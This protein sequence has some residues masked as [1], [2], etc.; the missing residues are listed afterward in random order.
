M[1]P[2][3]QYGVDLSSVG[4]PAVLAAASSP[5]AAAADPSSPSISGTDTNAANAAATVVPPPQA[6]IAEAPPAPSSAPQILRLVVERA[7]TPIE[8]LPRVPP[9][10]PHMAP[11]G[12]FPLHISK[13]GRFALG[14]GDPFGAVHL[15]EVDVETGQVSGE[16]LLT[17]HARRVLCLATAELEET[18]AELLL[19]GSEDCTAMLWRLQ[20]S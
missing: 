7:R 3:T 6:A 13:T 18:G 11:A 15:V 10:P 20:A 2:S 19:T 9:P 8:Q 16:A 14:A 5:A 4:D 1:K 17:G 12:P